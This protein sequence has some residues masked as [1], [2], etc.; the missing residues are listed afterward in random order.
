MSMTCY[1]FMCISMYMYDGYVHVCSVYTC[2][3]HACVTCL[4]VHAHECMPMC[5]M[6]V[7]V[8]I[9]A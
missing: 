1:L 4:C 2:M 8:C 6:C 7:Y 5:V 9:H 3:I